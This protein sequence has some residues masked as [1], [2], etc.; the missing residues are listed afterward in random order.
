MHRIYQKR[1]LKLWNTYFD[2][3]AH[4]TNLKLYK[5]AAVL[6]LAHSDYDIYINIY[7]Y[8]LAILKTNAL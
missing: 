2:A 5:G 4:A 3:T 7:V 8:I 1:T 6:A